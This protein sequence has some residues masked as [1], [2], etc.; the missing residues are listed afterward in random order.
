[1]LDEPLK[2]LGAIQGGRPAPPGGRGGDRRARG[3]RRGLIRPAE[4]LPLEVSQAAEFALDRKAE[5]VLAL[6]LRGVSSA[7]DFFVLATGNSDIQVRAIAEHVLEGLATDGCRPLHVEGMDRARWVLLDFVDFV[8]HVFHPQAREFYQ[9]ELSGVTLRPS[10]SPPEVA[11]SGLSVAAR[12]ALG[13]AIAPPHRRTLPFQSKGGTRNLPRFFVFAPSRNH[14]TSSLG[15]HGRRNR[16]LAFLRCR[17]R[18]RPGRTQPF[19]SC[20]AAATGRIVVLAATPF[21]QADGWARSGGGGHRT[22]LG[23]GGPEDLSHGPGARCPVPPRGP[24]HPEPRRGVGRFPLRGVGPAHRPTGAGRHSSSSLPPGL[25]PRIR[26]RSSGTPGGTTWPGAFRKP[27]PPSSSF[28]PP[29]FRARRRSSAGPPTSSFWPGQ[30]GIG[31][32][33][34]GPC[35]IKV[36]AMAGPAGSPPGGSSPEPE[37][38]DLDEDEAGAGEPGGVFD[39]GDGV[40][41]DPSRQGKRPRCR[42]EP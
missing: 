2:A 1:M 13:E 35:A 28:C 9:L 14:P 22:G 29:T 25:P 31:R 18:A 21:A 17:I 27:M 41:P 7:T 19:R 26:N 38:A 40:F 15:S 5:D 16:R 39:F 11:V 20:P 24:G 42:T 36:V 4:D 23:S 32:G 30:D 12:R 37:I 34:S 8:V 33:P 6:D 10:C 3:A